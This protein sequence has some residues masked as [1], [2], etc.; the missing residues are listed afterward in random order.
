MMLSVNNVSKTLL[1]LG[2]VTSN[3]SNI[4]LICSSYTWPQRGTSI[5]DFDQ[6]NIH[7]YTYSLIPRQD[8]S[9][10]SH[11]IPREEISF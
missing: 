1:R 10:T 9:N 6:N 2:Y 4:Q 7:F 8:L 5:Y 3:S 11:L